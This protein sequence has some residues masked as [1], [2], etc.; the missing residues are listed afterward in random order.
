VGGGGGVGIYG[1]GTSGVAGGSGANN[2]GGRAGSPHTGPYAPSK[3]GQG[4]LEYVDC[5]G[6]TNVVGGNGG[7][8][9]GGASAPGDGGTTGVRYSGLGGSG[10]VRVLWGTGRSFPSTDVGAT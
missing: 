2:A 8:W 7:P 6:N 10:L 5:C 1:Q 3:G 9:G 4:Y